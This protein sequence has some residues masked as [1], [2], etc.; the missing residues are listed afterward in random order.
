MT[1]RRSFQAR[2]LLFLI[3]DEID[4]YNRR[5]FDGDNETLLRRKVE[6]RANAIRAE[7]AETIYAS[8]L[9]DI[10]VGFCTWEDVL[11]PAITRLMIEVNELF[12]SSQTFRKDILYIA[13][14]YAERRARRLSK[15]ELS[16]LCQYVLS[17]IPV[18]M[19]GVDVD[20]EKYRSM[21]YPAP[22]RFALDDIVGRLV[23]GEYG[24]V[25]TSGSMIQIVKI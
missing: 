20:N 6:Q 21:I 11:T 8:D 2:R 5:V 22:K 15:A 14:G 17:E 13:S 1:A 25:K 10:I 3:A 12:L 24:P 19:R 16:Y 23:S 9:Q 4:L 7:I 18:I